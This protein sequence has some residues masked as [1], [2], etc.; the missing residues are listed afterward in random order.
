LYLNNHWRRISHP[1]QNGKI[2]ITTIPENM[3]GND[4]NNYT[5]MQT[6][7]TCDL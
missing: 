6:P 2:V 4:A 3:T 5:N 1:D 7:N